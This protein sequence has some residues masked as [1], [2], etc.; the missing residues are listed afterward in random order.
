[1]SAATSRRSGPARTA[2]PAARRRQTIQPVLVRQ[3]RD[4]IVESE[5]R[6][7]I[8]EA[9]A[10]GRLLHLVGDAD[11][12][13]TLRSAAKPF[14]AVALVEA[15]GLEAFSVSTEELALMTSS[16]S[17]EDLHVRT[18]QGLLR[19]A[20]IPQA[21]LACGSEGAP[22]DPLTAARILRDGERPSAIRHM[23]SG[24]HASFLLLA[25]LN[26]W[27]LEG[28]WE[29]A[30]PAM[31]AYR[32]AVAAVFGVRPTDLVAA[33]DGC[34]IPT[35]AFPLRDVA[36]AYALLGD[37]SAVAGRDPRA[38]LA[39]TLTRIRDAMAAHPELVAGTRDRLDSA[40]M[41]ALPGRLVAK[42]GREGLLGV[43]I[44]PN[45]PRR[46]ASG[47]AI[48]VEDGDLAGRAGRAVAVESLALL[49]VLD[50][51]ALRGLGRYHRPVELDPH[52]RTAGETVAGFELA[53]VGEL[54]G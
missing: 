44:L 19:R 49:G 42:G 43:G 26:G 32:R 45:A 7:S 52:G 8:V 16:H 39:P 50:G 23:C 40:L 54:L 12:V 29:D 13:V 31:D 20:K 38:S 30:H 27:P 35:F 41:K 15:G 2:A 18:L 28:Y 34:G 11:R 5:H 48:K 22:L 36:R 53:P 47:L 9:D 4:G 37:P 33:I 17:G 1:V 24:H 21:A 6:G 14:G 51:S 25:R 46:R 10:D 3:L